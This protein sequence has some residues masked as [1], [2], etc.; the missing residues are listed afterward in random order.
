MKE[1]FNEERKAREE[2]TSKMHGELEILKVQERN[3]NEKISYLQEQVDHLGS[4]RDGILLISQQQKVE[5]DAKLLTRDDLLEKEKENC[6]RS[7]EERNEMM[8]ELNRVTE[9]YQSL[10]EKSKKAEDSIHMLNISVQKMKGDIDLVRVEKQSLCEQVEK[11]ED[12]LRRNEGNYK[13]Q[14]QELETHLKKNMQQLAQ[15]KECLTVKLKAMDVLRREL[16]ANLQV[17]KQRVDE[18]ITTASRLSDDVFTKNQVISQYEK[19]IDSFKSQLSG[20]RSTRQQLEHA[21]QENHS[22][23]RDMEHKLLYV[24]ECFQKSREQHK[25]EVSS[26]YMW[27]FEVDFYFCASHTDGVVE[28]SVW[29]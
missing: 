2:M 25:E 1:D 28:G 10:R 12:D 20:E 15:E 4:D 19:D 11:L 9:L 13:S 14:L 23:L 18:G 21:L 5:F 8:K 17:E 16:F 22:K 3:L 6:M 27:Q 7:K 24:Q 26:V 29:K